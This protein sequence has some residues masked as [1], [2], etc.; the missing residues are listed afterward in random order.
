MA[1][2]PAWWLVLPSAA[3]LAVVV[4]TAGVADRL[5]VATF[6]FC[7]LAVL[8]PANVSASP[9]TPSDDA[10]S[11]TQL[12]VGVVFPASGTRVGVQ[13]IALNVFVGVGW[14]SSLVS[15]GATDCRGYKSCL[16]LVFS[17]KPTPNPAAPPTPTTTATKTPSMYGTW[18]APIRAETGSLPPHRAA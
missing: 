1:G 15:V 9:T 8:E 5:V 11:K 4:T 7:L 2:L 16:G 13:H 3:V 10:T 17:S 12:A 6:V 18:G 14:G